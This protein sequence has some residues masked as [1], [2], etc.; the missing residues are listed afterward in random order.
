MCVVLAFPRKAFQKH[1]PGYEQWEVNLGK[2]ARQACISPRLA[3]QALTPCRPCRMRYSMLF[4]AKWGKT[5]VLPLF[6]HW[7]KWCKAQVLLTL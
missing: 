6:L 5:R 1:L 7:C 2:A 3:V 4:P